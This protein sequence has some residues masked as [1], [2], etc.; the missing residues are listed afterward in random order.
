[1]LRLALLASSTIMLGGCASVVATN[2][3]PCRGARR[4]AN[5]HGSVLADANAQSWL[6]RAETTAETPARGG[7]CGARER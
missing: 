6:L 7:S 3:E 4:P 2:A 5:L 1:M